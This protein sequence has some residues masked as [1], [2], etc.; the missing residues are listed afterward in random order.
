M[1]KIKSS[2]APRRKLPDWLKTSLPKGA[3]YFRLKTLV[4]K[5]GLNTVCESASCP[6]IGDCWSTGTLTLMIL[7]DTCTRSCRFCDVPTGSMKP[8]RVEEPTEI[9]EMLSKINLKYIV[10]TSVDRD[11]LPDGGSDIWAQTIHQVK[12]KNPS[13]KVE[14]LIPDFKGEDFLIN[15]IC[16]A[17]PDVVAHNIETVESLQSIVRP[18]C[19]Y[20]W[21]L[22]VLENASKKNMITKSG[23][24]LGLGERK[25]EVIET[26]RHLVEINCRVLSIGQYLRPSRRHLEVVEYIEPET[27]A[28]YKAIGLSLGIRHVEAGPLVRSSYRADQQTKN[29]VGF[30]PKQT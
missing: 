12:K 27:F 17:K 6:N 15:K 18:Q 13:M 26:M 2:F 16:Q 8:P 5:Y 24:M 21:S 23:L 10:I 30:F 11:D 29:L 9:A 19:R 28:E 1:N 3:N 7:G 4:E 25:K 20:S 22:N 14:A